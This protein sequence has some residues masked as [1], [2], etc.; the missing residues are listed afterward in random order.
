VST[1]EDAHTAPP[2][3]GVAPEADE[4]RRRRRRL[5]WPALGTVLIAAGAGAWV[6]ADNGTTGSS[7]TA[8]RS[9]ATATVERGTISATESWDGTLGHG[10]PFT[11][12][13][14]GQGVITRLAEQGKAVERGDELFRI[15][16]QPVTLLY[17][18]VPMYRDL[19][20]GISG[21]DAKQLKA[22]LAKLGYEGFT[23]D[24]KYT[25]STANAVRRWQA[26]IGTE[27]T[28][29]VPRS[30][31]VFLPNGGRIDSHRA[32]VGAAVTPGRPVVDI[33][34]T[35]QIVSLEAQ[36]EDRDR[37]DADTKVTI[38]LPDGKEVPG[39]VGS[40]V[41][42]KVASDDSGGGGP[43]GGEQESTS[44]AQVDVTLDKPVGEELIGAPVEVIVAIDKRTDVLLVPVNALLALAEGGNGLEIVRDDG[45]TS[46]VAVTTGL[47]ADGKV[48]VDGGGIAEGTVVG[49]AGR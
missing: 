26:D 48:Q 6:W 13:S 8:K 40:M 7:P 39:T 1:L 9:V 49:A 42:V 29:T 2:V 44:I 18:A 3:T 11:V 20:P 10:K 17:G 36:V 30:G 35:E 33:T 24:D 41:V 32:D 4:P 22:N 25:S 16:E 12:I 45:T 31:V 23:A 21:A 19:R 14:F 47:F 34:G 37:F 15:D 46:I 43:E 27:P 38:V 5:V 28:G